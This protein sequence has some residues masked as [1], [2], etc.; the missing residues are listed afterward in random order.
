MGGRRRPGVMLCSRLH[1]AFSYFSSHSFMGEEDDAPERSWE[2]DTIRRHA[3][4]SFLDDEKGWGEDPDSG[5]STTS[6]IRATAP[7]PV[8]TSLRNLFQENDNPP[9]KPMEFRERNLSAPSLSPPASALPERIKPKRSMTTDDNVY[10][11]LRAPRSP[12]PPLGPG[13]PRRKF[14]ETAS[15]ETGSTGTVTMKSPTD[16][17]AH[18][19]SFGDT[20]SSTL[21]NEMS[22]S[23]SAPEARKPTFIRPPSR[24]ASTAVIVNEQGQPPASPLPDKGVSTMR[25]ANP[26]L[27]TPFPTTTAATMVQHVSSSLEAPP[28][29]AF[30]LAPKSP[31]RSRSATT[32]ISGEG[33][34]AMRDVGGGSKAASH[35]HWQR[36]LASTTEELE[37]MPPIKPFAQSRRV[38]SESSGSE[39]SGVPGLRDVLK[40]SYS[41]VSILFFFTYVGGIGPFFIFG[42]PPGDRGSLTS[43]TCSRIYDPAQLWAVYEWVEQFFGSGCGG[44]K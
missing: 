5:S 32:S 27:K 18:R 20:E 2:F 24:K 28:D 19:R 22:F 25:R 39:S 26:V 36:L 41:M 1:R 38:R 30:A 4:P 35:S 15:S 34:V 6:T 11:S 44:G 37:L 7:V 17:N 9:I 31:A 43:L 40:V 33:G 14:S 3:P 23:E 29:S 12:V 42:T 13:I 16:Q 10:P 8:P 21:Q